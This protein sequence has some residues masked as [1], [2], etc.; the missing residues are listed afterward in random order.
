MFALT[1]LDT[2]PLTVSLK[3]EPSLAEALRAE[4]SALARAVAED[5]GLLSI[6]D[7][8]ARHVIGLS[9]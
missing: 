8:S 3:C 4:N 7:V 9:R 2:R 5:A 6:A 1:D